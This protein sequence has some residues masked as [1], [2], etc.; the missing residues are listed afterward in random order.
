MAQPRASRS[1]L[2]SWTA[3]VP[4][5]A[6]IVLALEWGRTLP[7]LVA[8]IVSLLLAGA[9]LAAV[10]HAEVVAHRVGEPLGSLILA[11]A[12]TVIEVALIVTLMLAGAGAAETLARDTVF[13]A[14]ILTCNGIVGLSIL[15]GTRKG[16]VV[17]FNAEGAGASLATV[18]TLTTLGLVL[19]NF[20]TTTPGPVF[21][22]AQLTF[23]A[24]TALTLYGLF[25]TVQTGRH[26][27][28]FLPVTSDGTV[29]ADHHAT[30]PSTWAALSS[31]GLLVVALVAVVGDAKLV[32][33]MVERVVTAAG[34]PVSVVGVVIAILVLLPETLAAL[35]AARRGRMQI[36]MNQIGRAHV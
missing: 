10:H 11:V 18:A 20:T 26:R 24:I 15:V 14:V 35:R 30:P 29:I 6:A 19:P 34:F 25:V 2:L 5:I 3:L 21:S 17:L 31:L 4:I 16:S 23:A 13:A 36:S 9:V 27:D 22:P 1:I 32:S 28:Y 12:V 33:P 7:P 8:G